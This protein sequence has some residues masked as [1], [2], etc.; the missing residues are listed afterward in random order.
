MKLL[1]TMGCGRSKLDKKSNGDAPEHD[2]NDYYHK[3]SN[4]LGKKILIFAIPVLDLII[5]AH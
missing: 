2:A 3:K 5:F 4:S 1:C